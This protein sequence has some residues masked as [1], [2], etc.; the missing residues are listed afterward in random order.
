VV[1]V[2]GGVGGLAAASV[3]AKA[4]RAVLL[5]EASAQLGGACLGV[6]RDGHRYDVG[7]GVITGAGPG[8]AV[9]TLCERLE[10]NLPTIPCDPTM[11]LALPDHRVGLS[12][13][14][15][16]WWSEIH[17]EFPDEET[18]WHDLVSDL[19]SLAQ[20]RDE[21]VRRLPPLP[22]ESWG[23]RLRCWSMLTLR[24]VTAGTRRTTRHLRSNAATSFRETLQTY[25]LGA[26]SRQALEACLWYLLLRGSDECSTLEAALALQRLR[27]GAVV[28]PDGPS[29]LVDR[30]A[31]R[32]RQHGG[33][34]RLQT[35]AARCVAERGR[36]VGV[37]TN[38]GETI[39]ARWVVTDV[40]P[41]IL[42]GS[43]WPRQRG[44]LRRRHPV[45]RPWEPRRVAQML[46]VAIPEVFLPSELAWHCL[47]VTDRERPARDENLVFV[48]RTPEE[49][50]EGTGA[51]LAH[52]SVGRFVPPSA[53]AAEPA[54]AR[55]LL[56]ALDHVIPGVADVA[57][58]QWVAPPPVLGEL[59]GR[60]MAA[61]RYEADPRAWLGRRGSA[62]HV[63]WPGL[64]AV[65]DW[66]YP[67][68]QISDVVEGAMHVADRVIAAG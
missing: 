56:Q 65:G 25:G 23:D 5:L 49:R 38:A 39:R 3:L 2:G 60:P 7:V 4:G 35:A 52:L 40:P 1:V 55:A 58:H 9:A 28:V 12:L 20:D 36:V 44:W 57:V 48:R 10:M 43:L 41:G 14:H 62:H 8:G 51:R 15:E 66:T 53:P 17:R 67:G 31:E 47:V 19:S 18:G 34:I 64:L 59:W 16:G 27:D 50:G 68:R 11:Q 54:V 29:A 26:A 32:L 30:L 37:A 6:N 63:G 24:N 46:C 42:M 13:A 22:P 45:Q 33:E 61:V 21:L